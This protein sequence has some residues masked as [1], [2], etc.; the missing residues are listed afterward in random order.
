M[1]ITARPQR[2]QL[3]LS[4]LVNRQQGWCRTNIRLVEQYFVPG[5]LCMQH[6]YQ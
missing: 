2:G 1:V 5:L 6:L 4:I 3:Y